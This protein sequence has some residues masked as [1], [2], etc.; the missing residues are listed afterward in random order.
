MFSCKTDHS[1]IGIACSSTADVAAGQAERA[2]HWLS[3]EVEADSAAINS[4]LSGEQHWKYSRQM[5]SQV[6][7]ALVSHSQST[8]NA[9]AQL[10]DYHALLRI[11]RI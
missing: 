1:C 6:G 5:G 7:L 9:R 2:M 3:T 10:H 8:H 11:A 4:R